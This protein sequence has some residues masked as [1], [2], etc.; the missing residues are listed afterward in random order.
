MH[1]SKST[2]LPILGMIVLGLFLLLSYIQEGVFLDRLLVCSLILSF[3]F[4][5][6]LGERLH[7]SST[8]KDQ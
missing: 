4:I 2:V 1:F 8:N 5:A 6:K 7:Q 3:V